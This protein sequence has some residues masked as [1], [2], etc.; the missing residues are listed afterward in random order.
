M[1][2]ELSIVIP[3]FNEVENIGFLFTELNKF[4]K[5]F[6]PK[7]EII[8]V[9]DGSKDATLKK[10]LDTKLLFDKKL[11][12]FSKNFG[13]Q[14]ALLA[15]LKKANGKAVVTMDGDLQHP[16]KIILEMIALHTQGYDIV[17]TKKIDHN[18]TSG[19]KKISSLLFYKCINLFSNTEI[20]DSSSDFRLLSRSAVDSLLALPE[21]RIFLRGLVNWIG[22]KKIIIPF[23]VQSRAAGVS[24]Y[25]LKKMFILALSGI[26]SFSTA[27][28]YFAG[29]VGLFM[30]TLSVLYSVYVIVQYLL[31]QTVSGWTS[32]LLVLLFIG[33]GMFIFLGVIGMYIAA[34]YDEVK[35][36]PNYII[37]E[38]YEKT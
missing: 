31:H 18:V 9:D 10:I 21:K 5:K 35:N 34:I 36:R 17:L 37:K 29:I 2:Y 14:S 15:G 1:K 24:K 11:L 32:I 27:P 28:L 3:L 22:Y 7:T 30:T 38:I 8:L 13:H 20:V 6:P 23:A 25:S 16:P 19:F 26:T 12:I 4:K 33:S